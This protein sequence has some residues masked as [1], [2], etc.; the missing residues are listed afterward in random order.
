MNTMSTSTLI[1][2]IA[3][4][5]VVVIA[6]GLIVKAQRSKRLNGQHDTG[7]IETGKTGTKS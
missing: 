4:V 7:R 5:I 3:V 6:I 1:G 2:A